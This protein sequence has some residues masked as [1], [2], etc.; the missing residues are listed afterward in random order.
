MNLHNFTCFI[1]LKRVQVSHVKSLHTSGCVQ[2]QEAV[3][4]ESEPSPVSVFRAQ[5]NDP[6]SKSDLNCQNVVMMLQAR[7]NI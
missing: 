3:A 5:E 6:V 7:E 4:V 2:Q 1:R